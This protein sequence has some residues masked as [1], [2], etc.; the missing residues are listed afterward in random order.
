MNRCISIA[1]GGTRCKVMVPNCDTFCKKHKPKISSSY[2]KSKK[3]KRTTKSFN[4]YTFSKKSNI[5]TEKVKEKDVPDYFD[6]EINT[7]IACIKYSKRYDSVTVFYHGLDKVVTYNLDVFIEKVVK[8]NTIGLTVIQIKFFT[9][10][11]K[12]QEE[13]YTPEQFDELNVNIDIIKKLN[14]LG[15]TDK[16]SYKKWCVRNHPDKVSSDNWYTANELFQWVSTQ[17]SIC[18]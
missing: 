15:I 8:V 16:L 11:R 17:V 7:L 18:F 14:V 1:K 5:E 9:D 12:K 10:I 3:G 2:V 4:E 6:N 13:N